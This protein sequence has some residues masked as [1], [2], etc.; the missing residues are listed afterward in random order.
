MRKCM[1]C[2]LGTTLYRM[3]A[4]NRGLPV[5][6]AFVKS[7]VANKRNYRDALQDASHQF[8]LDKTTDNLLMLNALQ[9]WDDYDFP[10]AHDW[11]QLC[12]K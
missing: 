9:M 1:D 2:P 6:Y 8:E 7:L 10:D 11:L 3:I 4:E 12:G 5:W